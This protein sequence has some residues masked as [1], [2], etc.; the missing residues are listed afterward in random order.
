MNFLP[1]TDP[2][3][4][5]RFTTALL[6]FLWQGSALGVLVIAGDAMLT[7]AA[8]GWRY[9]SN[10]AALLLMAACL[11]VTFAV[12]DVPET[13]PI[14]VAELWP[15]S[16]S[17]A[18]S[19]YS[20]VDRGT[21]I[22]SRREL[23]TPDDSGRFNTVTDSNEVT[24]RKTA[25]NADSEPPGR[26]TASAFLDVF[27]P[28]AQ[29]LT[30]LYFV[31]VA[32]MLGRLATGIWGGHRL[33]QSTIAI[34]DENLLAATWRHAQRIGLRFAPTIA[35]CE[36][37]SIPVVIG[38]VKPIILLPAVL[39]SGLS[40]DQLQALITHELAHIRRFDLLVN[41][42][43]RLI[44]AV[45]FFHPAVWF[46]SRRVSI[47][48]ENATD[49]IVL[50]AGWQRPH[51][52][53]A[54]VRMAELSSSLH[55][56]SIAHEG[57]G[58]A[59]SG[60]NTSDFKRRVMRLLDCTDT[61]RVCL[62]RSGLA[63]LVVMF[64]M[65]VCTPIVMHAVAQPPAN[66]QRVEEKDEAE[67]RQ[68]DATRLTK[69]DVTSSADVSKDMIAVLGEDR[70]RVWGLPTR[71]LVS[72]DGRRV[73][74]A[75]AGGNVSIYDSRSLHRLQRFKL[76]A[77]RCL[78]IAIAKG[79]TRLISISIDGTARLWDIGHQPPRELDSFEVIESSKWSWLKMSSANDG[80][81]LAIRSEEQ[82]TLLN[83]RDDQLVLRA[84]IPKRGKRVPFQFSLS[85]DGHW[86]A[87]CELL[88]TSTLIKSNGSA[89]R[90]RDA[91]LVLWD[92]TQESP[93]FASEADCKAEEKLVFLTDNQT[94]ITT[95]PSFLPERK[96]HV[97]SVVDNEFRRG[98][99]IPTASMDFNVP[100]FSADGRFMA[101]R[102]G[103]VLEVLALGQDNWAP[104][105]TLE[106]DST[107]AS[108]FLE[109]RS[110]LAVSGPHLQ[111]WD[112]KNEAYQQREPPSGH[113]WHVAGLLF[114][115]RT[116]SLLTAAR[117]SLLEWKLPVSPRETSRTPVKLPYTSVTKIW[118]WPGNKGFLLR[119]NDDTGNVIEG[120][121][122]GTSG[123]LLRFRIDFGNDNR[124]ACWSAALHP[125]A[126][127]LATGHWD[128]RIRIWDVS[129]HDPEE[130][131]AW[132]AHGGHVCDLAFSPD[133]SRLASAGWDKTT[134]LWTIDLDKIAEQTPV[135]SVIGEHVDV[136]RSVAFSRDGK[137]VASGGRDG[138]IL[139]FDLGPNRAIRWLRHA[140]DPEPKRNSID[141]LTVG[142]LEF[143]KDGTELLSAD[144]K[145]RVTIWSIATGQVR[146]KWQL[147]GWVW[148]ARYSPNEEFIATANGDGTIHLL[149]APERAV[150]TEA[151]EI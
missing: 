30:A 128:R 95:D 63:M 146:K 78:D 3:F 112:W 54:L 40:P 85:S 10:V 127:I 117:D 79:G 31:C 124:K 134:K 67:R 24:S 46:V 106:T 81:L 20:E 133:G 92:T 18:G 135:G 15:N 32:L 75:E 29:H 108:V 102:N 129:R 51:Y 119:R 84:K 44:E 57:A 97:W 138:Q 14:A 62:T 25:V 73:F 82:I 113:L 34:E 148:Q 132:Q 13:K 36:Q 74:L 45:L 42:L 118:P 87:T 71:L 33:R 70:A 52:A 100:A 103:R 104:I 143:S 139:L 61:T 65:S 5:L 77:Q 17:A 19:I 35:Y 120:I 39:A 122:R 98:V 126:E 21:E 89:N 93:R 131:M 4:S 90:Y 151:S 86:L 27:R 114:D 101:T 76:H 8:A 83:V 69:E 145:G 94:L 59:A 110:I 41:L 136:V 144:G 58:L 121:R 56:S 99:D 2:S 53:N 150:D 9:A 107:T 26:S 38:I 96:T 22:A 28:T 149:R 16:Q 137:H 11:P 12:L 105:A 142:S 64:V 7:R 1:W 50:E 23:K 6:H 130:I 43:Q 123:M 66:D 91:K 116:H 88:D 49:D 55:G 80:Q 125:T 141:D 147:P 111:R 115:S 37:I 109:D 47:E 140:E 72:P 68:K 48:R 60:T